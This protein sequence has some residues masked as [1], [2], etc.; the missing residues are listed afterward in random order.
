MTPSNKKSAPRVA[1]IC[2]SMAI[3]EVTG[4]YYEIF[5]PEDR[6]RSRTVDVRLG[7]DGKLRLDG[8][9]GRKA[10]AFNSWAEASAYAERILAP[11]REFMGLPG[12]EDGTAASDG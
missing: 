12:E 8:E 4:R 6:H 1:R 2:G 5:F 10:V 7:K 3:A 9:T 11:H